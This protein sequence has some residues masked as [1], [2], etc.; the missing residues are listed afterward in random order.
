M[1]RLI[2]RL[3]LLIAGVIILAACGGDDAAS[4]STAATTTT[5]SATTTTDATTTSAAV[6]EMVNVTTT[7]LGDVLA[8]G[9]G[10]VLYLFLPDAQGPSVCNGDCAAAWPPLPVGPIAGSGVD[11]GLMGTATRD[12]GTE[13]VTYNG[14]P[15]YYFQND[16]APGDTNGQGINDVWFV[17]SPDG[18]G[19]DIPG[20]EASVVVTSSGLGEI[21]TDD[22]GNTLYLFTPDQQGPSVCYEDCAVSWPPLLEGPVA[23]DG[24]NPSLLGT[25]D[26]DDGTTQ[27]T[28]GGWP[29][30]YFANDAAPGD[31]NGQGVNDVWF[32]VDAAGEAIVG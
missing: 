18:E 22:Q 21:L 11:A 20:P 13:Q 7:G 25:V 5:T 23:G 19:V 17:V 9:D 24:I 2:A 27:V 1:I 31:T 6:E 28:Y 12:D 15:L 14:W 26:R 32:V 4:D 8:D 30:Y 3:L 16:S 10:N 29:L